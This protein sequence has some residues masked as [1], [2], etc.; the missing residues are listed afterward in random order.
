MLAYS[1][2]EKDTASIKIQ[3][4]KKFFECILKLGL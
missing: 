2:N 4:M 3:N 1:E